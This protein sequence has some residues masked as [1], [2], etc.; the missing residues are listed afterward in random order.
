[1]T[2]DLTDIT[3]RLERIETLLNRLLDGTA[4]RRHASVVDL[5]TSPQSLH[6]ERVAEI[7]RLFWKIHQRPAGIRREQFNFSACLIEEPRDPYIQ[8]VP[9]STL[10]NQASLRKS[11]R[12]RGPEDPA[13]ETPAER[14]RRILKDANL[15]VTPLSGTTLGSSAGTLVALSPAQALASLSDP[16][17]LPPV[18]TG[19]TC[20]ERGEAKPVAGAAGITHVAPLAECGGDF[21]RV[22]TS[23]KVDFDAFA[24]YAE[25]HET[26]EKPEG[27]RVRINLKK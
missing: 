4:T 9:L 11:F 14:A 19:W 5:D 25:T 12:K 24:A 21:E 2:N 16:S 6:R 8:A 15:V 20:K 10:V 7:E 17:I 18:W 23:V 1:M 26:P 13:K 22:W 27:A 3:A